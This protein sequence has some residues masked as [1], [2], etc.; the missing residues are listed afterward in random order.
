MSKNH[1]FVS[2]LLFLGPHNPYGY[3]QNIPVYKPAAIRFSD[4]SYLNHRDDIVKRTREFLVNVSG[5]DVQGLLKRLATKDPSFQSPIQS[6]ST[7]DGKLLEAFGDAIE[8]LGPDEDIDCLD[9]LSGPAKGVSHANQVR[10]KTLRSVLVASGISHAKMTCSVPPNTLPFSTYKRYK[11][12]FDA[13][14]LSRLLDTKKRGRLPITVTHPHVLRDLTAHFMLSENTT[15]SNTRKLKNVAHVREMLKPHT[16]IVGSSGLI[17]KSQKGGRS[18]VPDKIS[19]PSARKY[20]EPR[21]R[22]SHRTS[23]KCSDCDQHHRSQNFINLHFKETLIDDN[24]MEPLETILGTK[25][26]FDKKCQD[27]NVTDTIRARLSVTYD[28]LVGTQLHF[29]HKRF[30][31]NLRS[32]MRENLREGCGILIVDF[33]QNLVVGHHRVESEAQIQELTTVTIFAVTLEY[34]LPEEEKKITHCIVLSNELM[35]S[36]FHACRYIEAALSHSKIKTI[37]EQLSILHGWNDNGRHLNSAEHST[38]VLHTI[39]EL[40]SNLLLVTD[41]RHAAKH[42]KD[43]ADVTIKLGKACAERLSDT[44]IGFQDPENDLPKLTKIL[45]ESNAV[46]NLIRGT[47]ADVFFLFVKISLPQ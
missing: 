6:V 23:M 37:I 4:I 18:S 30:A 15:D 11:R 44:E 36:S 42:G 29:I 31:L 24:T 47:H 40:F 38:F 10:I 12:L 45:L 27:L 16:S 19:Y 9:V 34:R 5:G 7:D 8:L 2:V 25:E 3:A 33:G 21:F 20:T 14:G 32:E 17:Q 41:N 26:I 28:R 35:H 13:E 46:S 43:T 39:P 22:K 1:F